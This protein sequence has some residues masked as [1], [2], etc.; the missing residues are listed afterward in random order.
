MPE[1]RVGNESSAPIT[2]HYEDVGSGQP[3]VLVHGFPLSGRSWQIPPLLHAGFRVIT[4]DR[5]GFVVQLDPQ[6]LARAGLAGMAGNV[7]VAVPARREPARLDERPEAGQRRLRLAGARAAVDTHTVPVVGGPTHRL[8][9]ANG[10]RMPESLI[11]LAGLQLGAD[12]FLIAVL[13]T[14]RQPFRVVDHHG[15]IRFANPAAISTL[16]YER[17]DELLG[18]SNH[19][20]IRYRQE[21][22]TPFPADDCPLLQPLV[23][24]DTVTGELDWFVRRDGSIFPVS[25]VPVPLEPSK[26]RSAVVT[27]TDIEGRLRVDEARGETDARLAAQYADLRDELARLTGEQAALRRV[28]TL[29]ARG[30]PAADLFAT[31]ALEV[32]LL[33]G[34]DATHIGRYEADDRVT[35]IASW[36]RTGDPPVPIG[37]VAPLGGENVC[38]LVLRTGRPARVHDY[39]A[40]SGPIAVMLRGLGIRSSVGAPIVVDGRRWGAAIVSSKGDQP[41]S[42][43]AEHR[44]AAFTE[45]VATAISNSES[46]AERGRLADEQA[47]LRRVATLVAQGVPPSELFGAVIAEV[48]RLLGADLTGMIRYEADGTVTAVAAWAAVGEHPEVRGRWSLEGER[49]ATT[50]ARTGRA[51]REDNWADVSGPIAEFVRDQMG[52]K[53]TVGS[54]IVVEGT[55]WGA[56]VVHST[57]AEPLAAGTEE[58]LVDFTELVATAISNSEARTEVERLAEEQA[59]LR[60][61]ATLVAHE[62]PGADVFAAVA[63]EVGRLLRVDDTKLIRYEDD[64]TVTV[65]ASWGKLAE[66][67]PVGTNMTLEGTSV[68]ALVLR[69]ERPARMDDYSNADGTVAEYMRSKGMRSAVGTPILVEGRVWGAVIIGSLQDEPLPADT[70]LRVGEFTELIATAIANI[71]TSSDLAASRARLVEATVEERRRVVRDLH[72]G[73]QQRL[74]HTIITLKLA[75]Q[76]LPPGDA[77]AGALVSEALEHAERATAE[78]RELSHGILPTV[79]TRGGL[80]AGV[81][82][83]AARMPV[84]IENDVAVGR[85]PAVAEATAYFVVA[86]ALTNVA[87]HAH[88]RH[89]KV[90]ASTDDGTLHVHIC[91]DG[92]GGAQPDGS[93]L[94]GLGDRLTL[95]D[96]QLR[97]D[98]PPG[99]GT[100]VAAAIPIAS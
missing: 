64:G 42:T 48:G 38:S 93:G 92:V 91:D 52:V 79:L 98:S 10:R 29:V 74:V 1:I 80:R 8:M 9:R 36:S 94:L 84:P 66:A 71:Q 60:R 50:I 11:D 63:D 15:A 76:A 44:I 34:G 21:G 88:A 78:L 57:Q 12:E 24:G 90:T 35:L 41:L 22:G 89:A 54:P 37:T 46:Q 13:E 99:G 32:G 33:V 40:A 70:E 100:L 17:P 14:S 7:E 73:A 31:V 26:G 25:D 39:D 77:Q 97:I 55:V 30:V 59:G 4:Y 28:A 61:V 2:I 3:V 23:T 96:G 58:R 67:V 72:D 85:L 49:T 95:L 5:R 83:L 45:L 18:H 47:A 56:L 81:E 62:S 69:T 82:A 86:E 19:A 87:K 16:G 53:S 20:T 68:S 43:D 51:A 6:H 65:V 75:S 27:F